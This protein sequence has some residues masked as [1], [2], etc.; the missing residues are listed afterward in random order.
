MKREEIAYIQLQV[1]EAGR[2]ASGS[3]LQLVFHQ[4]GEP[5]LRDSS[6]DNKSE[7]TEAA[8]K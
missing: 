4:D 2:D 5:E 3:P 7:V 8:D 6:L 1:D